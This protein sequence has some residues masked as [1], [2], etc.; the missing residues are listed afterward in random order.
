M[1][2]AWKSFW[3]KWLLWLGLAMKKVVKRS[4]TLLIIG[5][6]IWFVVLPVYL[7]LSALDDLDTIFP[8]LYFKATDQD[9]WVATLKHK[10][11]ILIPT[12]GVKN[13]SEANLFFERIPDFSLQVLTPCSKPLFLRC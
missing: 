9:S 10:E 12:F 5:I 11:K 2:L 13:P 1:I 6:I 8:Y 3:D 4:R 7:H